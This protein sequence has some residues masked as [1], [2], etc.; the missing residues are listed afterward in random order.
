MSRRFA[1]W[2]AVNASLL[3]GM[4]IGFLRA[5]GL[6]SAEVGQLK[7]EVAIGRAEIECY[8]GLPSIRPGKLRTAA[9]AQCLR[10]K[11]GQ[12]SPEGR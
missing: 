10:E 12:G 5:D 1:F 6:R 8:R 4:G 2:V 9:A 11:V 3:V 7:A